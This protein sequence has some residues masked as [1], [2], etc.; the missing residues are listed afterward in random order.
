MKK[1]YIAGEECTQ[2][3]KAQHKLKQLREAY[4]LLEEISD[5]CAWADD[6]AHYET[7]REALDPVYT[8]A[9]HARDELDE[10]INI[11]EEQIENYHTDKQIALEEVEEETE[12][13]H[14]L[15]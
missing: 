15:A 9:E 7:I 4:D 1:F 10:E 8:A 5:R 3:E 2:L 6:F 13:Q 11:L 12:L 14:Y